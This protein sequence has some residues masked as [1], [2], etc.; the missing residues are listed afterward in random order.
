MAETGK[1]WL[2][3]VHEVHASKISS[4]QAFFFGT[5]GAARS[6]KLAPPLD[7]ELQQK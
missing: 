2:S 6:S 7:I 3:H 5:P 4:F 1:L